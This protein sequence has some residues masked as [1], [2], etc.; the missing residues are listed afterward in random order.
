MAERSGREPD[1]RKIGRAIARLAASY[2]RVQFGD[3]QIQAYVSGLADLRADD[4]SA[5]VETARRTMTFPP[6]IAELRR[7]V[8]EHRLRLP[9]PLHAWEIAARA[10]TEKTT[11]ELPDEIREAINIV[12]GPFA[13]RSTENTVALRAHFLRAYEEVREESYRRAVAGDALPGPRA[14]E[15]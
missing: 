6:A 8:A 1:E 10:A 15:A 14:I 11:R 13:I 3:A 12:G 9:L 5:A 7:L 4:V 2:P